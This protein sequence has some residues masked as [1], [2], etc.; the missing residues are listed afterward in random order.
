MCAR[1]YLVLFLQSLVIR[2]VDELYDLNNPLKRAYI[3]G[4]LYDP[5]APHPI[6][7]ILTWLTTSVL[8][9]VLQHPPGVSQQSHRDPRQV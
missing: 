6:Y 2:V 4:K 5:S 3:L 9:Q 8:W 1:T 7:I